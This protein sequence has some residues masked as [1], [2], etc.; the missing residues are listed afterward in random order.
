MSFVRGSFRIQSLIISQ[1]LRDLQ[2][3]NQE[4]KNTIV[5][6]KTQKQKAGVPGTKRKRGGGRSDRDAKETALMMSAKQF[7]FEKC[8]FI[9]NGYEDALMEDPEK[10]EEDMDPLHLPENAQIR[11]PSKSLAEAYRAYLP[12]AFKDKAED[13]ETASK[14]RSYSLLSRKFQSMLMPSHLSSVSLLHFSVQGRD[15]YSGHQQLRHLS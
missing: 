2:V 10:M 7:G 15:G 1:A 13:E 4:S 8:A 3:K 5:E 11:L 12:A 6:M 14:V 9:G